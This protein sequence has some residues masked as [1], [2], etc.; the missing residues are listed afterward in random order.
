MAWQAA[1]GN[2]AQL[3]LNLNKSSLPENVHGV[4]WS[5][6]R[7]AG[8]RIW[9]A[10][11]KRSDSGRLLVQRLIRGEQLS[12]SGRTRERCLPALIQWI[13]GQGGCAI[14]LDFPFS[15][16]RSLMD[17]ECWEE[18]VIRFA[19][20]FPD[21]ESFRSWCNVRAGGKELKRLTD[22][23]AKTPFSP[24]NLRLFRQTYWGIAGVLN[25]LLTHQKA[26]MLPMQAARAGVP[27]LLE[28]CPASLL[29]RLGLYAPYKGN[30]NRK[31]R[32]R[33]HIIDSIAEHERITVSRGLKKL[34]LDDIGGDALDATL[35][36]VAVARAVKDPDFPYPEWQ[37]DYA[38]EALVYS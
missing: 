29:K 15:L 10:S 9:I 23:V 38:L 32:E 2:H 19:T 5:G 26:V 3:Y 20:L 7:D 12:N 34:M 28:T 8:R 16:P 24:Y 27:W 25:P 22:R 18:F 35:A 11:A 36:A 13:S 1:P 6:A 31:Y 17:F 30:G 33:R 14:G 37:P 4:D 21:P